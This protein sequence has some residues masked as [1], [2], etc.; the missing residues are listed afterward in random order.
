MISA[1]SL[2]DTYGI[3]RV[4]KNKL[5]YL[6]IDDKYIHKLH[7]LLNDFT[8][9]MPDYFNNDSAGAHVSVAYPEER[10]L[11]DKKDLGKEYHFK[12]KRL[13]ST[14]INQQ[15]YHCLLVDSPMLSQLRI[16]YGL[17]E[18]LLFKNYAIGFHITIG[19]QPKTD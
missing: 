10:P 6:D 19:V 18:K 9:K 7:P 1:L 8:I 12:V 17:S 14:E 5:V 4:S 11:L 2:L 13:V 15:R 16:K 3:L